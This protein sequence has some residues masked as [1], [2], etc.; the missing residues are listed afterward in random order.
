MKASRNG[1][2]FY[3][4]LFTLI[5]SKKAFK[6]KRRN[7]MLKKVF[8]VNGCLSHNNSTVKNPTYCPTGLKQSVFGTVYAQNKQ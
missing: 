4:D 3:L 8:M 7:K 1:S 5:N 6:A 2:F